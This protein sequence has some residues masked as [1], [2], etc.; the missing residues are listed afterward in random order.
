VRSGSAPLSLALAP[1]AAACVVLAACG[2]GSPTQAAGDAGG[3]IDLGGPV[4]GDAGGDAGRGPTGA[5]ADGSAG[6]DAGA[7]RAD[8]FITTVVSYTPG[9]CAG[10]GQSS[11]PGIV[12]G[13]PVGGGALTGSTDVVSLGGGGEIVVSFAPNAIVDGPGPDLLVFENPF[14]IGGD[15]SNLYAEPGEV[16]VSDDGV[17]WKTFPCTATAFP[18]GACGGW[19]V[20][21]STPDNGISP[22]DAEAAGGDAYDLADVGLTHARFVRV[23]D[24]THEDCPASGAK[25]VTNGFDLDAMAILHAENP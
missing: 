22:L 3:P 25:P 16:S 8:R 4:G 23:V 6:R 24:K 13:P 2:S 19:H 7:V 15:P 1:I 20:V 21:N 17:T 11:M 14:E 12:M 18:Y 9:T 10:F 5:S